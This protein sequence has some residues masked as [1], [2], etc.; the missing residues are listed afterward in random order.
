MDQADAQFNFVLGQVYVH[1]CLII[2]V[3]II[4]SLVTIMSAAVL[5]GIQNVQYAMGEVNFG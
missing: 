4:S 5:Y 3:V 1:Y 2:I